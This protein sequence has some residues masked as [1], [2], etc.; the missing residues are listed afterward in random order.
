M[1]ARRTLPLVISAVGPVGLIALVFGNQWTFEFLARKDIEYGGFGGLLR[2]IQFPTWRLTTRGS[3]GFSY[4]VVID[5][6]LVLFLAVI[7]LLVM[8]GARALEPR[9]GAPGALI[10]GWWATV[11][12]G[13]LMGLV[14][15][16]LYIPVQDFP[17]GTRANLIWNGIYSGAGFGLFYGWLPGL[18]MLVV[19]LATRPKDA[20]APAPFGGHGAAGPQGAPPPPP[21]PAQRQ[22]AGGW[23]AQPPAAWGPP[24]SQAAHAQPAGYPPPGQAPF[25]GQPPQGGRPPYGGQAPYGGQPPFGGQA[26]PPGYP[27][28]AAAGYPQAP[29]VPYPP[30][31]VPSAADGLAAAQDPAQDAAQESV[32]QESAQEPAQDTGQGETSADRT[33]ETVS[34]TA[35]DA[36]Q[37]VSETRERTETRDDG[38]ASGGG[39]RNGPEPAGSE[40]PEDRLPPPT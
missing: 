9:R 37:T 31:P 28:H 6:S 4:L 30:P 26:P 38:E 17:E 29:P 24:Q 15:A 10:L 7:G 16:L 19:F 2:L 11:V 5:L 32:G 34:D 3:S 39:E 1:A 27:P 14:R 23:G 12:A 20:S 40:P 22:A 36:G 25:R 8:A 13:G 21:P 35:G 18:A 33:N